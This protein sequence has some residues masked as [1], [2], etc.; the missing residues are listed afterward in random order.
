MITV[1]RHCIWKKKTVHRVTIEMAGK[2]LLLKQYC[3]QESVRDEPHDLLG[4]SYLADDYTADT[5]R[6]AMKLLGPELEFEHE[7]ID[8]DPPCGKLGF[9]LTAD[10]TG[11]GRKDI[12]VGGAG[13]GYPG[14]RFVK[15]A[16][17][18]NL[19]TFRWV[20]SLTGHAE[21]N[22][23]WYENPGFERHD[24][25][26]V[27]NLDVGAAVGDIT[28]DGTPEIVVGQGL[29]NTGVY[30]FELP[31]DPRTYWTPHLLTDRFEKY[32]DLA[33]ADIDDDGDNEV[34]GLSQE[35][36]TVFY[37]DIPA[38]PRVSPWPD[39][40]LHIVAENRN[41]EGLA[42]VD[43]DG[44]GK[45]ELVAGTSIYQ[46][47]PESGNWCETVIADDWDH[48]RVA[49]ADLDDDDELE[50]VLSEGDSPHLGTHPGRV[51]WFDPPDWE[52]HLLKEDLFCPHSLQIA[53]FS[54]NDNPDI[55]LAEMGLDTNETPQ[56]LLFLNRG[57][58]TFEKR[59]IATGVET[60]EAK[61]T[62]M[63]GN[64][65]PDIVGKSYGPNHHVD[66][67][68]NGG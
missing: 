7:V 64:G 15:A 3:R 8:A 10:L 19:P 31:E 68:Y 43:L 30:W 65:S 17:Q 66:I 42:V 62:D 26:I 35:S 46:R 1:W 20:R 36:E 18:R 57:N 37:Y 55:Y 13:E 63:T 9:C 4:E 39:K 5:A 2:S 23:F 14:R 32:H 33:V 27:P 54:N 51:A 56:H 16:E 47:D 21:T 28:G 11:N 49:V 6:E 52:P 48:T 34:I 67:W 61:A 40:C 29:D 24:V 45:T 53:D 38:D 60:H 58:G 44:D 12:I 50:I 59:A 22:L 25:G 41:V